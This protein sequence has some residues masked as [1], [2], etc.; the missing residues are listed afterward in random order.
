MWVLDREHNIQ[1]FVIIISGMLLPKNSKN[2]KKQSVQLFCQKNR[3][4]SFF[5]FQSWYSH[6]ISLENGNFKAYFHTRL[7][8]VWKYAP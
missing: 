4:F 8:L 7:R 3:E 1:T 2:Q 6:G 5:H